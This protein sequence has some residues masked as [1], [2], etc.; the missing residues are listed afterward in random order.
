[1]P[2]NP[3]FNS[4]TQT[5]ATQERH[6]VEDLIVEVIKIHGI[7]VYVIPRTAS[8]AFDLVYG[9]DPLKKF[10][11]SYG[12]EMYMNNTQGYE[13]IGNFF[14]KFGLEIRD[15]ATFIVSRRSMLRH[16]PSTYH[17][18]AKGGP[19]EGDLIWVPLTNTLFE[20]KK[21]EEEK[22][23][24]ALGNKLPYYYEL[25]CERYRYSNERATTGLTDLDSAMIDSAYLISLNLATTGNG[26]FIRFETIYSSNAPL[27]MA[28][29]ANANITAVVQN[30]DHST[31]TLN[32]AHIK[33]TFPVG[34]KIYGANSNASYVLLSYSDVMDVRENE[35]IDNKRIETEA[36]AIIDF[37][38]TNPFGTP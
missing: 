6:L 3:Y 17:R 14:S 22:N 27:T 38:V 29:I 18:S 23:F 35:T 8:D 24:F 37:T 34:T 30:Y 16:V 9:E 19:R 5:G 25:S 12:I 28:N 20:I 21:V 26:Q 36:N 11:N 15:D 7:D 4:Q 32:V 31:H 10:Q 2:T 1:M 33:G 13:G